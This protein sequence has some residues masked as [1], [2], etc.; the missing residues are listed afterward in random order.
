[1]LPRP[2]RSQALETQVMPLPNKAMEP[3]A[4]EVR[5]LTTRV[6]AVRR[7]IAKPLGRRWEA[8]TV[9]Y[10]PDDKEGTP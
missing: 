4:P 9:T 1:M 2:S 5:E 10:S 3:A 7:L 6:S 8:H